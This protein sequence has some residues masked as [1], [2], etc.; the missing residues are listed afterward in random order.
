MA[1][2]TQSFAAR[3]ER[4]R[5]NGWEVYRLTNGIV[6]LFVAPQLG[7]RAIQME[8]GDES[9]CFVNKD[10]AGKVLPESQN[11]LKTGW[12]NYGGDKVWPAPEGW[13]SDQEWPCIPYYVLDGSTFR[14]EILKEGPEEVVYA[15][16]T[17]IKVDQTMRNISR[18]QIRW[19]IWHVFQNDGADAKDPSKPNPEL[20]IYIPLNQRSKYP[21]GYYH[22]FGPAGHPSY[23][24]LH[25]GRML[26]V[27]YLYSVGKIGADSDAGWYA[28]VNGQKNIAYVETFK[29][30]P[31]LDYPDGSSV[32]S[33]NDGP[34][35]V[36]RGSWDQTLA[37]DPK[38]TP[39]FL[40]AETVSPYAQLDPSEEYSFPVGWAP[41]R[42]TN[43]IRNYVWAGAI[44]ES[45]SGKLQGESVQLSGVFGV[46]EPGTMEAVF[47][48]TLGEELART[49]LEAVDPRE[50]VRLNKT[51]AAPQA[52]FRVAVNVKDGQDNDLGVLGNV[53]LRPR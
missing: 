41:T 31:D 28:V 35:I 3:I 48:G 6:S 30:F 43:P 42:V 4:V 24:V 26:R 51:L 27:H 32:E 49:S 13:M 36:Y 22:M 39:Y 40:E 19:G 12:A 7:G 10:L 8:L 11:N 2:T 16:T 44:S 29:Y 1:P 5:Y 45:L 9:Y 15:G 33:W 14:S 38:R 23:R 50:V 21:R 18:R 53:I 37:D 17:R 47:Y 25:G 34:G 46:F 52:A 20:Y